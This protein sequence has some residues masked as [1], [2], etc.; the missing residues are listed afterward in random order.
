VPDIFVLFLNRLDFFRQIF[1]NVPS[2][3]VHK[4]HP[5]GV[6]LICVDR[7]T[8]MANLYLLFA[9]YVNVPKKLH[10]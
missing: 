7:W 6:T 10:N 1:V 9:I 5:V 3:E 4:I 8:D 2:I